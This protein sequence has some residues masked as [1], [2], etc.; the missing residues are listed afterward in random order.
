MQKI[1]IDRFRIVPAPMTG[2]GWVAVQK[3]DSATGVYKHLSTF[4]SREEGKAF[5]SVNSR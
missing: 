1:T 3:W 2:I 4:R 5:I